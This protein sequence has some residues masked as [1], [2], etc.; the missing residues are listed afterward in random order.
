MPKTNI[1][2][3]SVNRKDATRKVTGRILHVGNI[4][5]PGLLHVA[6]LRSPYPHA[7]I[8]GIEKSRAEA[9][10]GV[11]LVLTGLISLSINLF[12]GSELLDDSSPFLEIW[13]TASS[14][15]TAVY[16]YRSKRVQMVLAENDWDYDKFKSNLDVDHQWKA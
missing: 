8:I 3:Q 10:E 6:V 15:V 2:G 13:G 11:V 4:E 1:V 16:F 5:M 12:F 9:M 14:L 7:R